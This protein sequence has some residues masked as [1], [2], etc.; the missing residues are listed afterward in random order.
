MQITV[1][2][3]PWISRFVLVRTTHDGEFSSGQSGP[4]SFYSSCIY[5]T[6]IICIYIFT[7]DL[8]ENSQTVVSQYIV[9]WLTKWCFHIFNS[10]VAWL[11]V[12]YLWL[13]TWGCL[14]IYFVPQLQIILDFY[15]IYNCD[16]IIA[17]SCSVLINIFLCFKIIEFTVLI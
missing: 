9:Y 15:V 11:P 17:L 16:T 12:C 10:C 8:I 2:H 6:Y 7:W 14:C 5:I 4:V 13:V 3:S 1:L